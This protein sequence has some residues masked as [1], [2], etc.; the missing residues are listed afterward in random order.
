MREDMFH[1][2][3][4]HCSPRDGH[5]QARRECRIVRGRHRITGYQR[6][7]KHARKQ[8]LVGPTHQAQ[9]TTPHNR[10]RPE[11]RLGRGR[12]FFGRRDHI[13]LPLRMRETLRSHGTNLALWRPRC[14]YRGAQF[15]QR[16]GQDPRPTGCDDVGHP[17]P[18]ARGGGRLLR[19]ILDRIESRHHPRYVAVDQGC[20][21]IE[22]DRS[23]GARGVATDARHRQ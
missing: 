6:Q 19:G 8:A 13:H 1:G 12:A 9:S 3:L 22:R 16:L 17:R 18:V 4:G 14:A 10:Q 20:G 7:A 23:H 2:R 5:T 21:P 15:H 11:R